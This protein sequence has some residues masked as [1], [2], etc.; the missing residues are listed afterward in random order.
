MSKRM[1]IATALAASLSCAAGSCAAA[2]S[3]TPF[4]R[5]VEGATPA[6]KTAVYCGPLGCGPIW[7]GP[8]HWAPAWGPWGPTYRPACPLD[9]YYACRRGPLGY[10]Q[11]ACWPYPGR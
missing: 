9:Y 11:C 6:Q 5:A 2:M 4:S 3:V 10:R 8:R 7:P 1:V